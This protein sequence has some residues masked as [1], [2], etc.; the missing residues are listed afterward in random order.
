MSAAILILL[1]PL[2]ASST[3]AIR[4]MASK[5]PIILAAL[6]KRTSMD[7]VTVAAA[8]VG[9]MRPAPRSM[10]S[11]TST[12]DTWSSGVTCA[13]PCSTPE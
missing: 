12:P 9:L 11:W 7:A 1:P 10:F 8:K 13:P 4:A 2:L 6:A 3:P 5:T